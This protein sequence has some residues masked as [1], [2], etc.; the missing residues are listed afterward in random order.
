MCLGGTGDM[1][2]DMNEICTN[3][4]P[5]PRLHF[6]M[7][8]LSPFRAVSSSIAASAPPPA[9]GSA[10]NASG[11]RRIVPSV[12]KVCVYGVEDFSNW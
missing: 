8:A 12:P 5:Y 1:N 6:L 3:L 7:T 4:V 2:V 10:R 11:V 9:G